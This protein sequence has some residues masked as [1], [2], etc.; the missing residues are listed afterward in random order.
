MEGDAADAALVD[1][2]YEAAVEPGLWQAVLDGLSTRLGAGGASLMW[3]D[4]ITKVGDGIQ[5]G[6]DPAMGRLFFSYYAARN[7]LNLPASAVRR[8]LAKPQQ[9]PAI[10]RDIDRMPKEAFVRTEFYNDFFRPFDI[11]SSLTLNLALE[12]RELGTVELFRP[13]RRGPFEDADLAA[14]A[15]LHAHLIRAFRLGRKLAAAR[16]LGESMA[17]VF[18][19][20][21]YGLFLLDAAARVRNLNEAAERLLVGRDGLVVLGGRLTAG[22]R[23]DNDRLQSLI[24]SAGGRIG[25]QKTGGS[26]ALQAAHR[27]RPLSVIVAPTRSDR[28]SMFVSGPC[29]LVCVTDP[30]AGI[31]VPE[32]RLRELYGLSA[33]ETRVALGL[34]EGLDLRQTAGRLGVSFN[35]VRSH[36]IRIFAKTRTT[37]QVDL[38]R[39]MMSTV[40]L[41]L[42]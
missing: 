12:G 32:Q 14:C 3:Q 21:P 42:P 36:L 22:G 7:P 23:R 28:F 29:V 11:H 16:A 41:G 15:S 10:I 33:A 40:G 20:S 26:M 34:L 27:S 38:T 1:L 37:G 25:E 2:I 5:S 30:E 35:T 19:R 6:L 18:D 31:S 4:Q 13:E 17:E 24:V 39:L 9:R 8:E